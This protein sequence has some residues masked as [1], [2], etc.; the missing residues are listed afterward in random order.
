MA[1]ADIR[2]RQVEMGIRFKSDHF[3]FTDKSFVMDFFVYSHSHKTFVDKIHGKKNLI[4]YFMIMMAENRLPLVQ[5]P[6]SLIY[7]C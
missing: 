1:M 2:S 5:I 4:W 7:H 6:L 3:Q